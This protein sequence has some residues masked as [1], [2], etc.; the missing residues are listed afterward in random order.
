[1]TAISKKTEEEFMSMSAMATNNLR[2]ATSAF[3]D[4]VDTL[5]NP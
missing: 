2:V 3:N 1:L 4:R 5:K